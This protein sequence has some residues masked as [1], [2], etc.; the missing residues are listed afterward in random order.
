VDVGPGPSFREET[1]CG[2][3]NAALLSIDETQLLRRA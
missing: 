3:K 1:V 2:L